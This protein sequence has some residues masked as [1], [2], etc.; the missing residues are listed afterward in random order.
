VHTAVAPGCAVLD[1]DCSYAGIDDPDNYNPTSTGEYNLT[2]SA[3]AASSNL[4]YIQ[5]LTCTTRAQTFNISLPAGALL[6]APNAAGGCPTG[7]EIYKDIAGR[8][9]VARP[10]GGTAGAMYG[11]SPIAPDSPIP[12]AHEHTFS[13]NIDFPSTGIALASGCCAD[14]YGQAGTFP[15][16][17]CSTQD[18]QGQGN[19]EFPYLM[20]PLCVQ[21]GVPTN[22]DNA[23]EDPAAY[24]R[25]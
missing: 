10:E 12:A 6:F 3:L 5:L 20:A 17:G 7:W 16:S 8:L 19:I 18:Q 4:P 14:G 25:H 24:L 2:G 13:G 9:I 22:D 21:T 23:A 11:G 1:P 15:F